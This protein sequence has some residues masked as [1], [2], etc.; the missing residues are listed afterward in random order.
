MTNETGASFSSNEARGAVGGDATERLVLIVLLAASSLT[1]MS[2]A[3][4]APSLPGL[5]DHFSS[6]PDAGI[7][8]RLALT[9]PALFI[10]LSAPIVGVLVDRIG[11]RMVLLYS[12]VAYVVAG[13]SG[14]FVQ[15]LYVLLAG[16]ALLGLAVAGVMVA[17]TTLIAALYPPPSRDRVLGY[18]GAAMSLGG[19]I[20]LTLGGVLAEIGWRL[21]FA[22]YALPFI[23]LPFIAARLPANRR[24]AAV[25]HGQVHPVPWLR[26]APLYLAALAAMTLFYV[27]PTQLPFRLAAAGFSDASLAGYAIAIS[28]FASAVVSLSFQRIRAAVPS[29]GLLATMFGGLGLGLGLAGWFETFPMI[30]LAMIIAG[31]GA[32]LTMPTLNSLVLTVTPPDVHGRAAGGLSTSIFLGQFL[33]PI[34]MAAAVP[35]DSVAAIFV[36]AGGASILGAI[37]LGAA[38]IL[39]TPRISAAPVLFTPPPSSAR[40]ASP[41]ASPGDAQPKGTKP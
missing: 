5:A 16:R 35:G 39:R 22:I 18:Q 6:V 21:P 10:A 28:T 12:A 29:L 25:G 3:T 38:F 23:L 8:A 15:D 7:L 9:L 26:L 32:G 19:V 14:L 24:A 27:I 1:V 13:T 11:P 4:I 36:W 34:V 31:A 40:Q 41:T 20:F 17:T 30:A 37:G 33:S 2:G